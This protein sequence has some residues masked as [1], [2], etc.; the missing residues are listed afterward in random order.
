MNQKL[1]LKCTLRQREDEVKEILCNLKS[2]IH[3]SEHLFHKACISIE[4]HEDDIVRGIDK[5]LSDIKEHYVKLAKG[6]KC[7]RLDKP[8]TKST[9]KHY[10]FG[11][12]CGYNQSLDDMLAKIKGEK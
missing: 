7:V 1:E 12:R 8:K 5:A 11:Y 6:C 10:E 3:H 4:Q 9:W 2:N